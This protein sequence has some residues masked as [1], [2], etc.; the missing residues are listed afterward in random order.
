MIAVLGAAVLL[1]AG[2]LVA[3]LVRFIALLALLSLLWLGLL[4]LVFLLRLGL[5]LCLLFCL[6]QILAQL[7]RAPEVAPHGFVAVVAVEGL[8]EKRAGLV[9]EPADGGDLLRGQGSALSGQRCESLCEPCGPGV[10][11][12]AVTDESLLL[13]GSGNGLVEGFG[14]GGEVAVLVRDDALVVCLQGFGG[15]S[16]GGGAVLRGKWCEQ[17]RQR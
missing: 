3:G 4:A 16:F 8:F 9:D 15:A 11:Q 14:G 17:H 12:G 2:L 5:F 10:G 6:V 7:H 13:A 1:V